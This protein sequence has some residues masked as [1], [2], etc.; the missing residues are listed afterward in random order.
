VREVAFV[1]ALLV[2]IAFGWGLF[3]KRKV[4]SQSAE[5]GARYDREAALER[6]YR[7]LVE[8]ATDVVLTHD[9]DGRI[10]SINPAATEL[11]GWRDTRWWVARSRS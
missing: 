5:I 11:L 7:E 9:L 3:L 10:T 8:N 2:L 6:R 4:S 1:G